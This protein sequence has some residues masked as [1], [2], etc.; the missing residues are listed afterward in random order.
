MDKKALQ[1]NFGL[2]ETEVAIYLALLELGEATASEIALKNSLNRT[3]TY[4]RLDQLLKRGLV[5]Y[6]I[7]DTKKYFKPADPQQLVAILQEKQEKILLELKQK[8]KQVATLVPTLLKLQ[9][10]KEHLPK[11]E[12]YTTKKGIKTIL[13]LVLKEN[14]D[15]YIYGSLS[16]FQEIMEHYFEIWNKQR[17][18]MGIKTKIISADKTEMKNIDRDYLPPEQKETTTTFTFGN[19]VAIVLWSQVPAGILMESKEV[20]RSNISFFNNI[21]NRETKI[22]TGT[23]GIRQAYWE[24]IAGDVKTF[25]GY[26]YSKKFAEIYTVDFSNAWHQERL[27]KGIDNKII[28]YDDNASINYFEPRVKKVNLFEVGYLNADLQGP[29]CV[30]FCETIVVNFIYTED[31]FK[32][33]INKNK[34]TIAAY[35]K[36]FQYLWKMAKK[37]TNPTLKTT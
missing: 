16:S 7:K 36:H 13:N 6:Y 18:E 35:K 5:S 14:K 26:G 19:K 23:E 24:M 31:E 37:N 25:R 33:I 9:K 34:E 17:V 12:L 30:S 3:F 15:L 27:K 10:P 22:Y 4:D 2:T 29:L 28:S 8:E 32:V 21:W 1:E 11:V 20:A